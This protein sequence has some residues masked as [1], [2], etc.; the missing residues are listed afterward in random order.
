MFRDIEGWNIACCLKLGGVGSLFLCA[1]WGRLEMAG[2]GGIILCHFG[3]NKGRR[4]L[5]L[6]LI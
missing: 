5:P 3:P 6:I 2:L 4:V 1:E